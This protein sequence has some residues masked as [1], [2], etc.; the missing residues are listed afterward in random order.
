VVYGFALLATARS[1]AEL[2]ERVDHELAHLYHAQVNPQVREMVAAFF[3]NR[4]G[5]ETAL[6][7]LMWVEGLAVHAA[8]RLAPDAAR[9]AAASSVTSAPVARALRE[10][11]DVTDRRTV[12][13]I[14]PAPRSGA[15]ESVRSGE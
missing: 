6:Y 9:R 8:R 7:E 5:H 1:D 2:A 13:A 4:G 12:E 11:M 3:T 10:R 15:S 14:G